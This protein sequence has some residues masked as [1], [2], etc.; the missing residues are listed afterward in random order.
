MLQYK[1]EWQIV[2]EAS[3]GMEAV[4][5]SEDLEPALIVLDIGLPELNGIEAARR[6]RKLRPACKILF[7]SQETSADI[8]K[9][10]FILGACGYVAKPYAGSELLVA[11]ETVCG[12]G[13]FVGRGL[14]SAGFSCPRVP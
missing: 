1:S 13:Q 7:L 3:N 9:E 14:S 8:V 11:I 12:G 5:K 10:A 2:G 6:I 4:Q